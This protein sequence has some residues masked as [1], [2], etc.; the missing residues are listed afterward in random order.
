VVLTLSGE[1]SQLFTRSPDALLLGI[2]RSTGAIQLAVADRGRVQGHRDFVREQGISDVF[3][4]FSIHVKQ[5]RIVTLF[6]KSEYNPEADDFRLRPELVEQLES[7]LK[8]HLAVHY[9]R[10]G[11]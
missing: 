11:D 9:E 3:G 4:G 5:G 8:Q 1:E 2:I 7:L 6:V 10:I